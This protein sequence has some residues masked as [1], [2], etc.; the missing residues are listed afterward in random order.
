MAA[1]QEQEM[2]ARIQEMNANLVAAQAKVPLA[3][4]AS[5]RSGRLIS[6]RTS[7]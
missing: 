7:G 5:L 6:G 1:A 3:L 2:V 4:A